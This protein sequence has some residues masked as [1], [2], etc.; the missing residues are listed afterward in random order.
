MPI[1]NV[2]SESMERTAS[3]LALSTPQTRS[4]TRV[5]ASSRG[6]RRAPF[7]VLILIV[8]GLGLRIWLAALPVGA[9]DGDEATTGLMARQILH[10]H[11]YTYMAGQ[12]Y[13][14][15]LE[16]YLQAIVW[17]FAPQNIWTLRAVDFGLYAITAVAVYHVG[18]LYFSSTWRPVVATGVFCL[19]PYFN[20]WK[21]IHS[22]GAYSIG[23]LIGVVALLAAAHLRGDEHDRSRDF[24]VLGLMAGLAVWLSWSSFLLIIPACFWALPSLRRS[25]KKLAYAVPAALLG[26]YPTIVWMVTKWRIPGLGESQPPTT[27]LRR[28]ANL[29]D[30]ISR[31]LIGVGY[32][33]GKPGLPVVLQIP[34]VIAI[35]VAI[36]GCLIKRRHVLRACLVGRAD[37][38]RRPP[39][40]L[41]YVVPIA[42][43]A[44]A[45]SQYAWWTGEPRYLFV[46]YP[47]LA[48]AVAA[49]PTPKGNRKV[50][51]GG[52]AITLSLT[53][54]VTTVLEHAQDGPRDEVGCLSRIT[55]GLTA[56]GINH[57]YSDYWTGMPLQMV[58]GNRLVV[59]PVGGGRAKFPSLRK[60]V[61]SDSPIF[62]LAGHLPDQTDKDPDNV[63]AIRK[64]LKSHDVSAKQTPIGGCAV[65]FSDFTPNVRP[66]QID[67]GQSMR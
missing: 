11:F 17:A 3:A 28:L 36:I 63:A 43:V 55:A 24:A 57:V 21:S 16:Q 1:P 32:R 26:A 62:Y 52:I 37:A 61:D 51:L 59:A 65:L 5:T 48:L 14:G 7:A 34:I 23:Q 33:Y 60:T 35:G 67:I 46:L 2:E 66:W 4:G 64:A 54:T 13:N 9:F 22:H 38:S 50:L 49:I 31:E 15:A 25:P 20:I 19:G 40:A 8:G 18:K 42:L 27:I 30:P 53:S 39:D 12:T 58:A 6:L 47:A 56:R 29:F 45:A 10:G 44:Y 41:L